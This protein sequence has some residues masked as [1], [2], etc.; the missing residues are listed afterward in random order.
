MYVSDGI[1]SREVFCRDRSMSCQRRGSRRACVICQYMADRGDE[2]C[3]VSSCGNMLSICTL[4][5]HTLIRHCTDTC[6]VF[7]VLL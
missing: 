6:L 3:E 7:W 5:K 4:H 2:G 1:V